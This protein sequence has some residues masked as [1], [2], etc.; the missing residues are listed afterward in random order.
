LKVIT[1][2]Y[3]DVVEDDRFDSSGFKGQGPARYKLT[4]DLF[5]AHLAALAEVASAPPSTVDTLSRSHAVPDRSLLLTFDDGGSSAVRVAE[6][7]HERG[8]RAHFFITVDYIG[9]RGFVGRD[10]LQTLRALGHLIGSHSCSHPRR[11]SACPWDVLLAEWRVSIERLSEM[12]GEAVTIASVPGGYYSRHVG[13]AA[14]EAGV[15]ALFT[16]EPV[17]STRTVDGCL[18]FGRYSILQQTPAATAAGLVSSRLPRARQLIS[19]NTKKAAKT[20]LG[21]RYRDVRKAVLERR[22]S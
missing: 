18:I 2:M 13:R 17:V 8:W 16:S 10:D 3:H 4:E 14:A 19:W 15:K 5:E 11:M 22:R 1:L 12:I 21:D 7:L 6:L 9:A 20:M